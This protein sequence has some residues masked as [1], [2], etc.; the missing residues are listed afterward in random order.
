MASA[1]FDVL[2][3][4]LQGCGDS[5]GD[6]G[7]ASWQ[8]WLDDLVAGY[9]YL[10]SRSLAP[11]TLW[12][13]RAGC[14]L[15]SELASKLPE[16]ANFVF[17]QPV[18]VGQQHWQQFMRLKMAG[19]LASGQSKAV[20]EK[21]RTQLAAGESVEIIGYTI[22]STL[23]NG[24]ES[25]EL[26][27]PADGGAT[28]VWLEISMREDLSISPASSRHIERWRTSGC[29]VLDKVVH[30]PSFWLTTEI[31]DA[32]NLIDATMAALGELQ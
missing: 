11:L 24:L 32:P 13:L 30:G 18:V 29:K 3:I 25:A 10:R 15:L 8:S 19:G 9:N 21:M 28:L 23:V 16:S 22:S 12:G 4:D 5:A 2:Q 6:F 14:L 7:D 20:G 27:P 17:W 26:L 31:E 1:G